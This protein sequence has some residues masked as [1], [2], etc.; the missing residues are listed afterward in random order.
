M[1]SPRQHEAAG[2]GGEGVIP[3][4]GESGGT[5]V[6]T[7]SPKTACFLDGHGLVVYIARGLSKNMSD[8]YFIS[9]RKYPRFVL[10]RVQD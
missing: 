8:G 3:P 2:G 9:C 7:K 5:I 10:Y 4:G 6:V 1:K